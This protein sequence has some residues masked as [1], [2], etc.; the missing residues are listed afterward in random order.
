MR[1]II[2]FNI[3]LTDDGSFEREQ[4]LTLFDASASLVNITQRMS[5]IDI[6]SGNVM[7]LDTNFLRNDPD[8]LLKEIASAGLKATVMIDPRDPDA[9]DLV[10]EAAL[11]NADGIKFH[12]YFLE[13]ADTD[14]PLAVDV[15]LRAEQKG[16]WVAV[17]CSYGTKNVFSISGA[18]LI[19]EISKSLSDTPLIALHAG[20]KAILDVMSIAIET[21]NLFLETSFSIPFWAGSSVET[22]FVF[23][24]RKIGCDRWIYGSDHPFVTMEDGLREID[25]F[26]KRHHFSDIEVEAITSGTAHTQLGLRGK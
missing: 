22:D 25:S 17:C 24:M 2:D 21:P 6:I 18:R 16:L 11:R 12:P 8:P 19:A 5:A 3:H 9:L 4:N 14:F 20:G 26:F 10:D 7:I 23:A 13:L 15:A 1:K